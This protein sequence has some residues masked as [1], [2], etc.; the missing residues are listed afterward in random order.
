MNESTQS[1][2]LHQACE[3]GHIG[4]IHILVVLGAEINVFDKFQKTPLICA[5]LSDQL[6]AVQYLIKAGCDLSLKVRYFN[7]SYS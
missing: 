5:I 2:A 7:I 1:T 4:I 6:E 3:L